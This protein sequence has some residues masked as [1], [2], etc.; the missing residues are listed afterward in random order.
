MA[1]EMVTAEGDRHSARTDVYLLG[2]ILYEILTGAP[3]HQGATSREVLTN[4][5]ASKPLPLASEV[6]AALSAICTRAMQQDPAARYDSA[7]A[8]REEIERFLLHRSSTEL[9][10]AAESRLATLREAVSSANH[11]E[12]AVR[13]AIYGT[14]SECRFAFGHALEIWA[15]NE[16]ARRGREQALQLM[17]D[18]ELGH[19]SAGAAAAHL[20]ELESPAR[21]LADRVEHAQRAEREREERLTT[22]EHESDVTASDSVRARLM[23]I[24][25]TGWGVACLV[26]AIL[27]TQRPVTA[28]E[29]GWMNLPHTFVTAMAMLWYRREIIFNQV[30]RRLWGTLAWSWT[31]Y[32]LMWPAVQVTNMEMRHA[33][34]VAM[35]ACAITWGA[36]TITLDRHFYPVP[37]ANALGFVVAYLR[38]GWELACCSAAGFTG[39]Y[40]VAF[41]WWRR[42]KAAAETRA[43]DGSG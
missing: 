35:Y 13:Q 9:S 29:F 39:C 17:I 42:A 8:F 31:G 2:S 19:G 11:G 21:E 14:F 3:P 36:L 23:F 4:A 6:P 27:A 30:N 37:V 10:D 28:A 38:P 33:L 1:P 24:A 12:S 20:A 32:L 34:G 18:F 5:F 7:D 40:A 26:A 15:G 25:G 16:A 22:M 43:R 41:L